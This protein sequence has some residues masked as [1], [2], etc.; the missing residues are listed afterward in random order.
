MNAFYDASE[1]AS[2]YAYSYYHKAGIDL[3]FFDLTKTKADAELDVNSE[4]K[5]ASDY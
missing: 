3:G 5:S 2:V 1:F 4:H